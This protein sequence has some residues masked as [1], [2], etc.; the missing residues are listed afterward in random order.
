MFKDTRTYTDFNGNVR[1][2]DFYFH[3]STPELM[4]MQLSS[5]DGY[6]KYME[7]I[8]TSDNG[9]ELIKAFEGI[10]LKAYGV[11]SDDGRTFKK[12]EEISK[13]YSQTQA[14]VDLYMDLATD[15]DF[16]AK[17]MNGIIPKNFNEEVDRLKKAANSSPSS[18]ALEMVKG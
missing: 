9:E 6:D 12:S 1:T 13:E 3:L 8:M 10:I 15:S 7:R 2:E 16:A 17:F 18:S 14:F 4:K 11:K 5:K